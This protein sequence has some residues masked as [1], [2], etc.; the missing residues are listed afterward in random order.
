MKTTMV[1]PEEEQQIQAPQKR[2]EEAKEEER[3]QIR[4]TSPPTVRQAP[5]IIQAAVPAAARKRMI[6]ILH[7]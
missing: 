4:K 2:A 3:E 1:L 5:G 6:W 7:G